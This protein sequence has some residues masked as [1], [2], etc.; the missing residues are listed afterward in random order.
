MVKT[1]VLGYTEHIKQNPRYIH[2]ANIRLFIFALALGGGGKISCLLNGRRREL[3]SFVTFS[4]KIPYSPTLLY[5]Y[6]LSLQAIVI[7]SGPHIDFNVIVLLS[8]TNKLG[9]TMIYTYIYRQTFWHTQDA[10]LD[11]YFKLKVSEKPNTWWLREKSKIQMADFYLWCKVAA[12]YV[13][14]CDISLWRF[15]IIYQNPAN[16]MACMTPTFKRISILGVKNILKL[17]T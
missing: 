3:P 2:N 13:Y 5:I 10:R 9:Y 12:S 11:N 14:F 16:I 17:M 6:V 7:N 4:L 8:I 1:V 15:G